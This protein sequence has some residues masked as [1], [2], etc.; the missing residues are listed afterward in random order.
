[1]KFIY[2]WV[3]RILFID[4]RIIRILFRHKSEILIE[5]WRKFNKKKQ[6]FFF[7]LL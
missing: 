2:E 1:M 5:S 3:I 4:I 7:Y 6:K